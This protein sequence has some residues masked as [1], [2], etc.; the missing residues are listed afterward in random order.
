MGSSAIS[1]QAVRV[2]KLDLAP[3]L[4][5]P[6]Y[7][8][9]SGQVHLFPDEQAAQDQDS[10][11]AAE[12]P[13]VHSVSGE[14]PGGSILKEE[15]VENPFKSTNS[16]SQSSLARSDTHSST[17]SATSSKSSLSFTFARPTPH[18]IPSLLNTK[19]P[20]EP[21]SKRNIA[22]MLDDDNQ[23]WGSPRR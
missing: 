4:T 3:D 16:G 22:E 15:Q 23:A 11:A 7:P 19:T 8:S 17:L 9:N 2:S 6:S 10:S 18:I 5:P 21:S 1:L 12:V 14:A 20:S 13:V